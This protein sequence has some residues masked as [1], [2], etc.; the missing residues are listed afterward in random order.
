M[1]HENKAE[2]DIDIGQ[3]KPSGNY[4]DKCNNE[5]SVHKDDNKPT[6]GYKK[7]THTPV[8]K[9]YYISEINYNG[10][11]QDGTRYGTIRVT[12]SG[13]Y[14]KR[15]TV[16]Y[17]RYDESNLVPLIVGLEKTSKDNNYD[18]YTRTNLSTSSPWTEEDSSITEEYKLSTKLTAI[19]TQLQL[20]QLVVLNLSQTDGEYYADGTRSPPKAN[21]TTQV[22]VTQYTYETVYKKCVH[23]LPG[24]KIRLLSTKTTFRSIPFESPIYGSEYSEAYVYFWE[25]DKTYIN[26]L[27]VQL[28]NDYYITDNGGTIWT[29]HGDIASG[30]IREKLDE[31]N[32]TRNKAHIIDISQKGRFGRYTFYPC[33]SCSYKKIKVL[34]YDATSDYSY[35]YHISDG[36][37]SRFTNNKTLQTGIK[38]P[39][40]NRQ[41]FVYRYPSGPEG[42][43]LLVRISGFASG[44]FERDPL[45]SNTWKQ[46]SNP[47]LIGTNLAHNHESKILKLLKGIL[48]TVT[49]D[50][51]HT[52]GLETSE[53]STTY[54]DPSE[55]SEDK[56]RIKVKRKDLE[57]DYVSFVH[58]VDKKDYFILGGIKHE[59]TTLSDIP[60]NLVVKSVTAYYYGESDCTL[61]KLLMVC[62]EKKNGNPENYAYYIRE[63]EYKDG[64]GWT[65]DSQQN[66]ELKDPEL[67]QKL[68]D[69]KEKLEVKAKQLLQTRGAEN[70]RGPGSVDLQK[71]VQEIVKF[72]QK[73]SGKITAS[74]TPGICGT[75]GVTIWKWP[76]ILSFLITRL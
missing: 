9:P 58:R 71:I 10:I 13:Y 21:P 39:Q 75:I 33:P 30:N 70:A 15:V 2:I 29:K 67:T 64:T 76:N 57:S 59:S 4:T 11:K 24:G 18:Y 60:S 55:G 74:V 63:D 7:Y 6:N 42:I 25:W 26:P 34:N 16:Y 61:E 65:L 20:K 27:L 5:I 51:G 72:F 73:T 23:K 17:L 3:T 54:L 62:L 44:W 45:D 19:T 43:P 53:K 66:T 38:F 41:A 68:K 47:K 46:V 40:A 12:A 56:E 14:E 1:T 37:I 50:I 31:Q 48:P 28:G 36:Y 69:L 8:N 22:H 35:F 49:I 32:C 52:N